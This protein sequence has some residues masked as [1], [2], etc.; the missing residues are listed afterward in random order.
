MSWTSRILAVTLCFLAWTESPSAA[1]NQSSHPIKVAAVDFVPAW[2]DLDGNIAR[3]AQAVEKAAREGVNYAVFP[4]TA[5]SGYLFSDPAQIAPY[6]DTIPG[7]TTASLLPILART[8]MYMSVGIA[9][10]DVETGLAYNSA[11]LLGPKGVIG[12]YRKIGLNPQDQKVFAPGNTDVEV[13]DTPIGRIGLVICYDD[14]YWQYPAPRRPPRRTDHWLAF[15]VGPR[16]AWN[17]GR[18]G[19]R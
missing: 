8:G 3:L 1:S 5:V 14:T 19:D 13:F 4:E 10:R 15:R 6:L 18:R 12:K 2:G 7:K 11:V 17:A 16:H 9:E